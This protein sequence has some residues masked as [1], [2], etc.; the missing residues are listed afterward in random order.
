[1][2]QVHVSLHK[3]TPEAP[4]GMPHALLAANA[5]DL[6]LQQQPHHTT[7]GTVVGT[8]ATTACCAVVA[9][10]QPQSAQV[11]VHM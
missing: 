2:T 1:M 6:I 4:W 11:V 5:G 9:V 8:C 10:L 7:E 3:H